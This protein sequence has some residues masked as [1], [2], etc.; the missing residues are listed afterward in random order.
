M[1]IS[2]PT[3]AKAPVSITSALQGQSDFQFKR[4]IGKVEGKDYTYH[5]ITE[6]VFETSEKSKNR[7]K[8]FTSTTQEIYS[9]AS[10]T[11]NE[12]VELTQ[13]R[14]NPIAFT[15]LNSAP[16]SSFNNVDLKRHQN[17]FDQMMRYNNPSG[18]WI[19]LNI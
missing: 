4:R 8:N 5:N 12:L 15:N 17:Y 19:D 11:F 6:N 13:H 18:S 10:S 9:S 7:G 3:R 16:E 2:N 14:L 1:S